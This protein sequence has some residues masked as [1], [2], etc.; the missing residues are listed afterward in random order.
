M[1]EPDTAGQEPPPLD[2]RAM[3]RAPQHHS[4][5]ELAAALHQALDRLSGLEDWEQG[6][7]ESVCGYEE[8]ARQA[9]SALAAIQAVIAR[10]LT[11]SG[12]TKFCRAYQDIGNCDC[13][14][15]EAWALTVPGG[16]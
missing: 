4:V 1:S 10:A 11:E 3:A 2:L 13:W 7:V 5:Y 15:G 6:Y 8:R 14:Y 16:R 12:H 9:E